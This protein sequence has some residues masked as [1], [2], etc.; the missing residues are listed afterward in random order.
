MLLPFC[1]IAAEAPLK[2]VSLPESQKEIVGIVPKDLESFKNFIASLP[3]IQKK[4]QYTEDL[5]SP[6]FSPDASLVNST[7]PNLST[8]EQTEPLL[9]PD[10]TPYIRGP[11]KKKNKRLTPSD[12]NPSPK[13]Q[14]KSPSNICHKRGTY[15]N[16]KRNIHIGLPSNHPDYRKLY[17]ALYAQAIK[18]E[19]A[20]IR[21]G[22][23][24]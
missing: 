15:T 8:Y 6:Y 3:R 2:N 13:I 22:T 12:Q 23:N 1:I 7:P 18:K 9:K 17:G 20:N 24:L 14:Q 19:A 11:Y 16:Q 4:L 5:F 21:I 10:G